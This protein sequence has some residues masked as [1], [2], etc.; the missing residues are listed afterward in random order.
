MRKVRPRPSFRPDLE[1]LERREVLSNSFISLSTLNAYLGQLNQ[2]TNDFKTQQAQLVADN[3]NP[4]VN[5]GKVASDYLT[6]ETSYQQMIVNQYLV[7]QA[8]G[9]DVQ[10]INAVAFA[11]SAYTGNYSILL[12]A[13]FFVDPQYKNVENAANSDVSSVHQQAA[14]QSYD[15]GAA[16][17]AA[18]GINPRFNRPIQDNIAF[19]PPGTGS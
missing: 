19:H 10:L 2:Q 6:A 4:G 16:L 7:Q 17:K 5:A 11:A 15:F 8:A 3:S 9:K 13:L 12:G 18:G 14:I 1:C